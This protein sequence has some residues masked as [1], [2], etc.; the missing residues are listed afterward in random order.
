MRMRYHWTQQ[1]HMH[2]TQPY[3]LCFEQK[4]LGNVVNMINKPKFGFIKIQSIH[5]HFQKMNKL[6]IKFPGHCKLFHP[7]LRKSI[8]FFC[9]HLLILVY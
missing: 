9:K 1:V 7:H 2:P 3:S 4:H 6:Q 8:R 5:F